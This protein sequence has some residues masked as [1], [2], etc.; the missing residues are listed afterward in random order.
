MSL[1]KAQL[2]ELERFL[3]DSN[4]VFS[5]H[6][7]DLGY[8]SLVQHRMD[9]G[10]HTPIKQSP[11]RLPFSQRET[12]SSLID[13]MMKKG[14]IQPSASA[15]ASPIVLVPKRDNTLQFCVAYRKVNPITKNDVYP[16]SRIDDILDTLG[17]NHYFTH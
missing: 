6:E 17:K 1:C 11:R 8:T 5:L 16:L 13:D 7:D 15:W 4:D 12:V 9:T 14:I 2:K 10:D 3:I